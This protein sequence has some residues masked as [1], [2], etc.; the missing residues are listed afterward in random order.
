MKKCFALA[1]L[2]LW[3]T[4]SA[5]AQQPA[6][7]VADKPAPVVVEE[8][9][10]KVNNDIITLTDL[11]TE[12][13]LLRA[14]LREVVKDPAQIDAQFEKISRRAL[15]NIIENKLI[16]QKAE[17]SGMTGNIDLDVTA[18]IESIRKQNNIP[19]MKTFEQLLQ[20]QNGMTLG[21]FK[22]SFRRD[23]LQR[24]V[25]NRFV[26]SKVTILSPEL[27]KF[28]KENQEK[29]TL[30]AEIRLSEILLKTEGKDKEEVRKRAD[31]ALARLKAGEDFAAVAT[32]LSEGATATK[33]GDIGN[34]KKG[35]MEPALDQPA[36]TLKQGEITDVLD[37]QFGLV[38][39][40][41]TE[42]KDPTVVPFD[43][44][45]KEIYDFLFNTKA[46]PELKKF[47]QQLK[48]ESYIEVFE[49]YKKYYQLDDDDEKSPV[50]G[51]QSPAGSRLQASGFR[52]LRIAD[53]ELIAD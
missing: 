3:V 5:L 35:T 10:A 25:I 52:E 22:E 18:A 33:G 19:D 39:L 20:K 4:V 49:K 44:V 29:F 15:G 26:Q 9:V 40:K 1:G 24:R 43:Q 16:L 30:P 42:R 27:E 23:F 14:Q 38:I 36:F 6:A 32:A 2:S 8:I 28:Y 17:E 47:I 11:N 53:G 13:N 46:Q 7:P 37:T 51:R 48:R 12:L 50:A 34:F 45:K 21:E 31:A 41:V